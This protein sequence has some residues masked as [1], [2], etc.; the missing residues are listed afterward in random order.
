MNDGLILAQSTQNAKGAIA[1]LT[2]LLI[3]GAMGGAIGYV[4][5]NEKQLIKGKD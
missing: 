5:W 3:L 4:A 2:F 1:M